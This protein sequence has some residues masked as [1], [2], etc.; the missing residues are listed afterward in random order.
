MPL[1][2]LFRQWKSIEQEPNGARALAKHDRFYLLVNVFKRHDMLHPWLYARCREVE[3]EPNG[4][5]DLWAREHYKSTIIT[6]AGTIQEILRN[7]EITIGIFSHTAP[8]AKGFLRQIKRELETNEILK[9]LFPD[10]L[11]ENP[12]KDAPNWSLD[13]GITVKRRFNSKESTVE[14]HGL[15]DGQPVSKHFALRVYD[16]VVVP[17]SVSTPEQVQKTTEAWELSDNLGTVEG[18]AWHIGTRYSFDDTYAEILKRGACKARIYAATDDGTIVGKPILFPQEVWDQKVRDQG[19]ATISCQMLQNPLAGTHRM[20]DIND[21]KIYEIRPQTLQVYIMVDPAH[22]Q[23]KG[24]DNTAIAV[25]G[26]DY[27]GNK[28][29]LDGYRH[30]MDLTERWVRTRDMWKWWSAA[31]GVQGISVGYESYGAQADL[32][33]FH[34][35]QRIER[36][37]FLIE[38]LAWPRD[39]EG[40]KVDR[41]QRLTPDVRNGRFYIPYQT[42]AKN[43]TRIQAE[44]ME[45]GQDYRIARKIIHKG[46][47]EAGKME[48]YDLTEDFKTEMAFFPFAGKKDLIDAVSRIFDMEPVTPGVGSNQYREPVYP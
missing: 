38:E 11:Y 23:K 15:V 1:P 22:S 4:Y 42:D 17:A 43:L 46:I 21:L 7:P 2:E 32:D 27:A 9:Q 37:P 20:F 18:C 29:L 39:G 35:R 3:R 36:M 45:S 16:D 26:I 5:L 48:A 28:Y 40:S 14:A 24:S 25:I 13:S 8:I 31:A 19:E 34:E 6:Y 30:K 41:V 12:W 44:M 47:R 10:I 33:Y